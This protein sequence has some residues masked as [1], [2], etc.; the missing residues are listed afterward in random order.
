M[1]Q[2]TIGLRATATCSTYKT[3]T[4]SFLS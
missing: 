3:V 4:L 1:E 2:S